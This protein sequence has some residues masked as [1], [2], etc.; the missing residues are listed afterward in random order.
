MREMSQPTVAAYFNTRKRVAADDL[1]G[2]KRNKVLVV[3]H[4]ASGFTPEPVC[5][6]R[7][8][9]ASTKNFLSKNATVDG[10]N[11]GAGVTPETKRVTRSTRSIKRIGA[12]TVD[13]KTKQMLEQ[14]KLVKFLKMGN[15]SPKKKMSQ[16]LAS[17]VKP[18]QPTATVDA[19]FSIK[20]NASNV[21][22][23]MK[24][25]TKQTVPNPVRP[26]VP[27]VNNMSLNEIKSKLSRSA[28]LAELKNSLNKLQNGFNKLDQLEKIRLENSK[29]VPV[30]P[31]PTTAARNLKEFQTI[32]V[33]VPMR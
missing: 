15:L 21:E 26:T 18:S 9:L 13:E 25:P 8:V 24:T 23:G 14:P 4:S 30:P 6:S 20:N 5:P 7:I 2:A 16:Q 27:S 11:A 1:G 29:P 3:E 28:R 10:S 32:E 33:E 31:S 22:R 12:V 17:P 19:E